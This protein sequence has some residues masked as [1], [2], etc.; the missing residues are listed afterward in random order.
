MGNLAANSSCPA[1]GSAMENVSNFVNGKLVEGK[2]GATTPL[3]DPSTGETYGAAVRS[4]QADIDDAAAAAEAAFDGWR[5]ETPADR[6]RAL[7]RIA[8]ALESEAGRFI[9]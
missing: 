1:K 4:G 7:L 9:D 8:D 2:D 6:G 3:V 5:K